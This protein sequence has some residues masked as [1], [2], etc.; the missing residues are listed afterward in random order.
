MSCFLEI[1]HKYLK[2]HDVGLMLV[3]VETRWWV[4]ENS[5]YYSVFLNAFTFSQWKVE[6]KNFLKLKNR[7]SE[8]T[9]RNYN[10]NSVSSYAMV[11]GIM[12]DSPQP[13][14]L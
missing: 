14:F 1:H 10:K 4:Y 8:K 7:H 3:T 2:C 6:K 12:G 13:I 5:L 9:E 11:V